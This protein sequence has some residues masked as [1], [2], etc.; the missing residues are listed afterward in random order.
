[1]PNPSVK[2]T[3]VTI[4]P[5]IRS[6]WLR[7]MGMEIPSTYDEMY[8]ALLGLKDQFGADMPISFTEQGFFDSTAGTFIVPADVFLE[9]RSFCFETAPFLFSSARNANI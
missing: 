9:G 4:G 8:E 7:E 5:A 1:M 6:D 3:G 2:S